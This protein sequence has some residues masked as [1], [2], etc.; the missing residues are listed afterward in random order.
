[1][2]KN[3]HEKARHTD[4]HIFVVVDAIRANQSLGKATLAPSLEDDL[5]LQRPKKR[6]RLDPK[7]SQLSLKPPTEIHAVQERWIR[8]IQC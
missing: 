5:I 7:N 1:M 2:W 6:R 8:L 3:A 4:C